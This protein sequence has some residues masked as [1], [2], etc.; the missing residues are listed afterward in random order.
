MKRA[1]IAAAL[2]AIAGVAAGCTSEAERRVDASQLTADVGEYPPSPAADKLEVA[3]APFK[4]TEGEIDASGDVADLA[5]DELA[6]L[7]ARTGRFT[8]VERGHGEADYTFRGRITRLL[9]ADD[10]TLAGSAGECA[11]ELNLVDATTGEVVS[12]QLADVR[13]PA[14]TGA[15]SEAE[16]LRIALD[17][18]LRKML[19]DVDQAADLEL[20]KEPSRKRARMEREIEEMI[21]DDELEDVGE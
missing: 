17:D 4:I 15:K 13:R 7:A 20:V 8:V 11:L 5:A 21:S 1:T 3:V 16:L 2:I 9:L 6:T 19:P 14:L 12:S 18:A 10:P